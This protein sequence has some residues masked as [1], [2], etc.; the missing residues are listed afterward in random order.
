VPT[1]FFAIFL[2]VIT[3]IIAAL[4]E[5]IVK[6]SGLSCSQ[7][8][9][10]FNLIESVLILVWCYVSGQFSLSEIGAVTLKNW[11][12]LIIYILFCIA[13]S[14]GWWFS[15]IASGVSVSA[16]FESSYPIFV[17]IFAM[18]INGRPASFKEVVGIVMITT[19]TIILVQSSSK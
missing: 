18:I 15:T 12:I 6:E 11:F 16:A 3:G 14:F 2:P 19:G 7:Y 13:I 5:R 8:I 17:L 1:W 4:Y 10:V 9:L